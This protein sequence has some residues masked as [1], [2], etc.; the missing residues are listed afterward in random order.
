M[1]EMSSYFMA[2]SVA[3]VPIRIV[4]P[5]LYVLISYP[6]VFS[7]MNANDYVGTMFIVAAITILGA[8]MGESIGFFISTLTINTDVAI[9]ISTVV[10]LLFLILGGFY[11]KFIPPWL[12]W[13]KYVSAL[14]YVYVAVLKVVLQ[15]YE[16]IICDQNGLF[17]SKCFNNEYVD[18][19]YVVEIFLQTGVLGSFQAPYNIFIMILFLVAFRFLAFLSLAYIPISIGRE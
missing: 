16:T 7:K 3:V 15:D 10:A 18:Y 9:S 1:Y 13:L 5:L 11:A 4:Q 6:M 12:D 19:R 8:V 17:I 14:R 2:K